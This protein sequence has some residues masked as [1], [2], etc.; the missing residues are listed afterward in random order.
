GG[1]GSATAATHSIF[2]HVFDDS[3]VVTKRLWRHGLQAGLFVGL[4]AKPACELHTPDAAQRHGRGQPGGWR[5]P[6]LVQPSWHCHARSSTSSNWH[7]H[8]GKVRLTTASAQ[9]AIAG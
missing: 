4:L 2:A 5:G 1:R 3:S 7:I 6:R 8:T 9:P